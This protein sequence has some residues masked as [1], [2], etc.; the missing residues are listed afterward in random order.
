MQALK[1]GIRDRLIAASVNDGADIYD[2]LAP[3]GTDYPYIVFQYSGGGDE[4]LSDLDTRNE[5]WQVKVVTDDHA[6]A[7]TIANAIRTALHRQAL[8]VTGWEHLWTIHLD[9]VWMVESV[10]REQVYHAGGTFRIRL[11]KSS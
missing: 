1:K 2:T 11:A 6:E 9:P 7:H 5:V 3:S 10:A 4:T 8:T